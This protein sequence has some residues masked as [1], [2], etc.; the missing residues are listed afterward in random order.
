MNMTSISSVMGE[1]ERNQTQ[2]VCHD[3]S[4]VILVFAQSN[5]FLAFQGSNFEALVEGSPNDYFE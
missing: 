5:L 2:N 1:G 4:Y 3:A